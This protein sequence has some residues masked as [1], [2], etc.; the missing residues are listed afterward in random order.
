MLTTRSS[1]SNDRLAIIDDPQNLRQTPMKIRQVSRLLDGPER[2]RES[3]QVAKPLKG[4]Q[5]EFIKTVY[6]V[7]QRASQMHPDG[8]AF[9]ES[10][11]GEFRWATFK[12]TMDEVRIIGSA[13]ERLRGT[14]KLIGIAGIQSIR[15]MN[16]IHAISAFGLTAVPLYHN[17]KLDTLCDIVA[18]CQL[19]LIFFDCKSRADSFLAARDRGDPR[20]V[21]LRSVIVLE[22]VD[23]TPTNCDAAV[24]VLN[25]E[26]LRNI[27]VDDLREVPKP[28][29][30]S[31]YVICH[32]SGTTGKP[33]G[34]EM[35]HRALVAVV[36]GVATSWTVAHDWKFG[37]DDVYFSFLS[38]AHI[39]EHLM[40]TLT[41]Y[42]GGRIGI[43]D[44]NVSTLVPQIQALQPTIISLVP[45]LL[46][47]L[48]E[49][50]HTQMAK[51]NIIAR[52]LFDYAKKT[53]IRQLEAGVLSYDSLIDKFVLKNLK[54]LIG[55]RAKVLTTGGAP[56][57]KEVKQF[58]RFAYGC[59][60]IEGYGQT[61]C[62]AGG[63]LT[64]PW[65]TTYG[66][67]GGPSPWAQVK[68]VDVPEKGYFA[69][70]DEGEVCFRGAALMTGYFQDVE[71][72]RATIDEHGWL[73]TGDI[74]R[75]LDNGA[76]QIVDRKNEMFKMSQGDFVSP[77]QIEAIYT[78]S[79]LVIQMFV[80]GSTERSFLVG[81]AVVDRCR[82]QDFKRDHAGVVKRLG[83]DDDDDEKLLATGEIREIFLKELN[84]FGRTCGLQTIE[85]VKN[86]RLTL[87]EFTEENGLVTSTLKNRRKILQKHFEREIAEMYSEIGTL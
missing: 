19:E 30:E 60:L 5:E 52:K 82:F 28:D 77:I 21:S 76:L 37:Q 2:I 58:S 9:G 63:T 12:E 59:P 32:T 16:C 15:Y 85:L 14:T 79:P 66:N 31:I 4:P 39:Y 69:Q 47:K 25:Y 64:L 68:L 1:S 78:N 35:S 43:Y 24:N 36:S 51:K 75:W 62:G 80:T 44:G 70:N 26:K 20:L 6:D 11:N 74:G 3:V 48:Y 73:H 33:K 56:L 41:L 57:T 29:P 40:Q 55:G 72:T 23:E 22:R 54:K 86:I 50:V 84:E 27:G 8:A 13:I 45:R 53:K 65:D 61:E 18:S 83:N 7:L 46:N 49:S 67:V 42:F 81:I 87:Q 38:L 10:A 34:V 71:L 17:S